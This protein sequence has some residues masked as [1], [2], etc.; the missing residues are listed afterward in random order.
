MWEKIKDELLQIVFA[1]VQGLKILIVFIVPSAIIAVILIPDLGTL[2]QQKPEIVLPYI[3]N[4][5]YGA[6]VAYFKPKY[7]AAREKLPETV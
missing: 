2:I 7:E 4:A 1:I 5:I 3:V 6:L